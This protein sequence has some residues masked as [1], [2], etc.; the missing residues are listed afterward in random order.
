MSKCVESLIPV[1]I[2]RLRSELRDFA[3]RNWLCDLLAQI[4]IYLIWF[5]PMCLGMFLFKWSETPGLIL[6]YLSTALGIW[7]FIGL[8]ERRLKDLPEEMLRLEWFRLN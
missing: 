3:S 6:V 8:D 5:G 2:F 1:P 7:L 4:A